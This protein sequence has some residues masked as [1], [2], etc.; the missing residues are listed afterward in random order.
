M[1]QK[2]DITCFLLHLLTPKSKQLA[3]STLPGHFLSPLPF[4]VCS[5]NVIYP[6]FSHCIFIP[7]IIRTH[8]FLKR[9]SHGKGSFLQVDRVQSHVSFILAQ[10]CRHPTLILRAQS[11]VCTQGRFMRLG[12]GTL[13][14]FLDE[15]GVER[16]KGYKQ[17]N[18]QIWLFP[19]ATAKGRFG[20]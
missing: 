8:K 10:S 5:F 12:L 19:E 9:L 16:R 17:T 18:K 3:F 15:R 4:F 11:L 6:F 13:P 20:S 2:L 14:L 1:L 7:H